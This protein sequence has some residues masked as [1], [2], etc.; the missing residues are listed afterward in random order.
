MLSLRWLALKA[1]HALVFFS[2][3]AASGFCFGGGDACVP[4]IAEG[5]AMASSKSRVVSAQGVEVNSNSTSGIAAALDLARSADAVVLA[6]GIDHSI[7]H[8]TLDRTDTALPGLQEE[9][10]KQV[11]AL[12]KPTI[13]VITNGGALAIDTLM[14]RGKGETAPYAIVEAFNPAK[15]GARALGMSLFGK[16]NRWGKLPITMYPHSYISEQSMINYDMSIAPGRTYK[17]YDGHPLF[18][19][20]FGLSLTTLSL[21]CSDKMYEQVRRLHV[22][23]QVRNHGTLN[24]DEV[25]QVYHRVIDVGKVDHPLPKRALVEFARVS[26]QAMKESTVSFE[27]SKEH[28]MVVNKAGA[29]TLYPGKHQIIISRGC[30]DDEQVFTVTLPPHDVDVVV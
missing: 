15:D 13:L 17:Y 25:V 30:S 23:C 29:K 9:F 3:Y 11:L 27:L 10:A 7:E 24:G 28:F 21:K 16:E 5:I 18:P 19:F 22:A 12:N 6:L 14:T 4:S 1:S 20:G 8:E 2:D 26:V